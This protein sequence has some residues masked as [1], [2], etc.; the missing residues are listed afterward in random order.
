M[1]SS[2]SRYHVYVLEG[3]REKKRAGDQVVWR[4]R[5]WLAINFLFTKVASDRDLTE[6]FYEFWNLS[7][8]DDEFRQILK[9]HYK[10]YRATI[11]DLVAD[12]L[13]D[14]D[15]ESVEVRDLA[16]FLVSA[17]EGSCILWVTDPRGTPLS[18][19]AKV[20]NQLMDALLE[21]TQGQ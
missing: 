7:R 11:A 3:A 1:I 10:L 21:A 16:A 18:R 6:A 9:E 14:S 12:C 20:G 15:G 2:L 4:R 19:L 5:E 8:H 17:F 13:K